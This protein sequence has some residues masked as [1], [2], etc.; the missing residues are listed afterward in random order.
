MISS[1]MLADVW[2]D[3]IDLDG[4][5]RL[6]PNLM[7]TI[8]EYAFL[9]EAWWNDLPK[10]RLSPDELDIIN[11]DNPEIIEDVVNDYIY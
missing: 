10:T 7:H 8:Y 4:A 9:G 5:H 1:E 2:I 3:G 11:S 6:S